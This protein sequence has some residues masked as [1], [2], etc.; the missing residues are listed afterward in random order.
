MDPQILGA[1]IVLHCH[2]SGYAQK[3]RVHLLAHGAAGGICWALEPCSIESPPKPTILLFR[4]TDYAPDP[5]TPGVTGFWADLEISTGQQAFAAIQSPL[6]DYIHTLPANT[7][8]VLVGHSLGASFAQRLLLNMPK[9]FE[10]PVE[11]LTFAALGIDK[12]A[13]QP[14]A[15]AA[16]ITHH[17]SC[18]QK[19]NGKK[20]LDPVFCLNRHGI[21]P[22]RI[23]VHERPDFRSWTDLH[24]RPMS[25]NTDTQVR[26]ETLASV[27]QT[28]PYNALGWTR[29]ALAY[30][31]SAMLSGYALFW[32]CGRFI[33]HMISGLKPRR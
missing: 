30:A 13:H 29:I 9:R 16:S 10:S 27:L 31:L 21:M 4:G 23:V 2:A 28:M 8:L 3:Y 15:A 17:V 19:P 32:R 12:Q 1:P 5:T 14:F 20:R 11:L 26:H 25:Q 22:G 6:M 33:S 24:M 18:W 7:P